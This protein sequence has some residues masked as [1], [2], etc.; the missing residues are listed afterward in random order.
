VVGR[1]VIIDVVVTRNQCG[2]H[3]LAK[4]M[5]DMGKNDW[6]RCKTSQKGL[7]P[8][9]LPRGCRLWEVKNSGCKI[10]SPTEVKRTFIHQN[11]SI[12]ITEK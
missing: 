4:Y 9:V 11:L 5:P 6:N 10:S 12:F 7:E 2:H 1:S 3:F 8:P